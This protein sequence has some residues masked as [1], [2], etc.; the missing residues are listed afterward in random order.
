MRLKQCIVLNMIIHQRKNTKWMVK[1]KPFIQE[2]IGQALFF[3]IVRILKIK[4]FQ[5]I[6]VNKETGAFLHQ[7]K[8][9][10]DNEIGSLDERW[11]WLE[12]WTSGHNNQNPICSTLH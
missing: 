2:K 12:G 6:L 9:L 11:N 5:L 3:S 4:L 7:F 10:E 8:W 1:N